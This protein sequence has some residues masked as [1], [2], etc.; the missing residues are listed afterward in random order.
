LK[1][2]FFFPFTHTHTHSRVPRETYNKIS[3]MRRHANRADADYF[4]FLLSLTSSLRHARD[5]TVWT[6]FLTLTTG[7]RDGHPR[8]FRLTSSSSCVVEVSSFLVHDDDNVGSGGGG[9]DDDTIGA[10]QRYSFL[11]NFI[12]NFL[13]LFM[14]THIYF[15]SLN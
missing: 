7:S 9:D 11:N 6:R 15:F 12:L 13:F 10:A 4:A 1:K 2:G 5:R 8:T 14:Y 3:S